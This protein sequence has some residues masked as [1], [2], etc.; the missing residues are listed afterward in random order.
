MFSI[1]RPHYDTHINAINVSRFNR[2][3]QSLFTQLCLQNPRSHIVVLAK[4]KL[5]L[6]PSW[7]CK[8]KIIRVIGIWKCLLECQNWSPVMFLFTNCN[9][10]TLRQVVFR[11]AFI[12]KDENF[13][14]HIFVKC[15][16]PLKKNLLKAKMTFNKCWRLQYWALPRYVDKERQ[17]L[18]GLYLV[19]VALHRWFTISVVQVKLATLNTIFSVLT[20]YYVCLHLRSIPL[21]MQKD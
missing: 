14:E 17:I 6:V 10:C 9:H 11:E 18:I 8:V 19:W 3:V 7:S 21:C 2:L 20:A 4:P 13:A 1:K 15:T 16:P 12:V 5:Q